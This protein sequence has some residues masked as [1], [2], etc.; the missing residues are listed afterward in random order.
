MIIS[1]NCPCNRNS[2]GDEKNGKYNNAVQNYIECDDFA[3]SY[4]FSDVL[5]I[6]FIGR[7]YRYD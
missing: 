4:F 5:W 1:E 2:K 6:V 7:T 3:L